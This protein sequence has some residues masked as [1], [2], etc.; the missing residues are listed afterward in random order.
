M[1]ALND[2]LKGE[3]FNERQTIGDIVKKCETDLGMRYKSNAFS[4][5][6]SRYAKNGVLQRE[7]NDEG[8]FVY[9]KEQR[10]E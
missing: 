1:A 8:K 4:G 5:P 6:L 10:G 3:F 2:L 9:F 7:K